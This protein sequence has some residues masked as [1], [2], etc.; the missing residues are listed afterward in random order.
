MFCTECS[1]ENI[2]TD[3]RCI[4]CGVN[5]FQNYMYPDDLP[6]L[7]LK[8]PHETNTTKQAASNS[9]EETV[10]EIIGEAVSQGLGAIAEGVFSGL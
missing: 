7:K 2:E 3:K 10:G 4:R 1:G 5:L 8:E 6:P 9:A